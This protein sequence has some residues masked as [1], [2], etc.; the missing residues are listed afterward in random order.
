VA[1][2]KE[3]LRW[4]TVKSFDERQLVEPSNR[5]G[6]HRACTRFYLPFAPYVP[7]LFPTH[8]DVD[9]YCCFSDADFRR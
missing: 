7:M 8:P 3:A 9:G 2:D 4:K 5:P 1:A 6:S